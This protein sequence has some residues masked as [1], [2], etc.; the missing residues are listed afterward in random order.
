MRCLAFRRWSMSPC[1]HQIRISPIQSFPKT[2]LSRLPSALYTPF[3]II[4]NN[5]QI[6]KSRNHG[7]KGC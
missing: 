1:L 5:V 4:F 6:Q 7:R 2:H 3:T